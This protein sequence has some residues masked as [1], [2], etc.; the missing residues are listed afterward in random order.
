[1]DREARP[2]GLLQAGIVED[3]VGVAVGVEDL[4]HPQAVLP[5]R[6]DRLALPA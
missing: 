1:V 5:D 6:R 4:E 2:G 3:V